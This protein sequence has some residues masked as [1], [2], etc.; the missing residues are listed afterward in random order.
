MLE[1]NGQAVR[2]CRL[3]KEPV[4]FGDGTRSRV[5]ERVGIERARVIVYA[6][7]SV[8]DERRGVAVARHLNPRVRI[9]VRTRYVAALDGLRSAGA[10]EVIPEEFETSIEIFSRV[11]R[12]YGVPANVVEREVTAVRGET[13]EALR[14][15]AMP[16]LRP[17][18]LKH[19]GMQA[20]IDTVEVEHGARAVGENPV[21]LSLRRETGATVIAAVRGAEI[22]HSPDPEFQFRIGDVVV[23]VGD[24]DARERAA[25]LFRAPP[26]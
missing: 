13:Y 8:G 7:A 19:L 26:V 4:Y 23:L 5:L 21:G 9:V 22:F 2:R 11:L 16:D 17:D 24:R 18:A 6:I 10:D 12:L 14:G 3:E 15:L 20:A 1:Q 25:A